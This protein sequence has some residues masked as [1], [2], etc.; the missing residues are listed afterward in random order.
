MSL[1]FKICNSLFILPLFQ[2]LL[3]TEALFC[4]FRGSFLWQVFPLTNSLIFSLDGTGVDLSEGSRGPWG[5]SGGASR[6]LPG[7]CLLSF[8]PPQPLLPTSSHTQTFQ[9]GVSPR[10]PGLPGRLGVAS[11]TPGSGTHRPCPWDGDRGAAVVQG[12]VRWALPLLLK[13]GAA[14][15]PRGSLTLLSPAQGQQR[16]VQFLLWDSFFPPDT[17]PFHTVIL[18]SCPP[19]PGVGEQLPRKLGL[20]PVLAF[21]LGTAAGRRGTGCSLCSPFPSLP[22]RSPGSLACL[23]VKGAPGKPRASRPCSPASRE[24]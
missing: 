21:T 19:E 22:P 9:A 18:L 6:Q 1:F 15:P 23:L 17:V 16:R 11:H 8:L 7:L 14:S 5:W 10:P 2:L 12:P 24:I 20:G 4:H 13:D 3:P